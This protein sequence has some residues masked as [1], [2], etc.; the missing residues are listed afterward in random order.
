M[1]E[2][3][4]HHFRNDP[5]KAEAY[6][7]TT[8][9]WVGD[10]AAERYPAGAGAAGSNGRRPTATASC[11]I[12]SARPGPGAGCAAGKPDEAAGIILQAIESGR[13][14]PSNYWRAREVI[15]AL[16]DR[17][18]PDAEGLKDA[19]RSLPTR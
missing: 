14:V 7:A 10:P 12:S 1:P 15:Q 19:F 5:S 6:V 3:P 4:E 8:L 9:S 18:L 16:D 2:R 13:L 11:G 17:A